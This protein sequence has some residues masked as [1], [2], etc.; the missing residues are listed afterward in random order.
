MINEKPEGF[1]KIS[2][3]IITRNEHR[4]I[5]VCLKS[6]DFADEIIVVDDESTDL[7]PEICRAVKNVRF[8]SRRMSDG[9][10][11]Q[12]NFALSKA[13]HPW[14]FSIDADEEVSEALRMEILACVQASAADGFR[15]KRRNLVFGRWLEDDRA[16][17][18][19]LFRRDKGSFTDKNVDEAVVV[20]GLVRDLTQT[21]YHRSFSHASV[22]NY[23]KII[24]CE[25]SRMT[26]RDLYA[27]GR[28]MDGWGLPVNFVLRPVAIFFQKLFI[29]GGW[30]YGW[31]GVVLA[32][33]SLLAYVYSYAHLG[34]IQ[35]HGP[36]GTNT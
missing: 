31:R 17:M 29:K 34:S 30:R 28:R 3:I 2:V 18:I 12:K 23:Y 13:L 36:A 22:H 35:R 4:C 33:F 19:R 1:P 6:V 24:V 7:T 14:I 32:Y 21:L 20:T 15:L 5:G 27:M 9:F 26:A 11:P 25:R 16:V 10:G 8:Y